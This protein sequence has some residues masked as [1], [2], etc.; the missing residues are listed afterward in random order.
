MVSMS[1]AIIHDVAFSRY[2]FW[3]ELPSLCRHFFILA[4]LEIRRG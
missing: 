2:R 3:K 1:V 4:T